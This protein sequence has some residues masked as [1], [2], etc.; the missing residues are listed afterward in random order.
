M[1]ITLTGPNAHNGMFHVHQT[2]CRDL[3]RA[4]YNRMRGEHGERYEEEHAS[5]EEVVLSVY[6]NGILDHDAGET[7]ADYVGEFKF[8]PCTEGLPDTVKGPAGDTHD[9]TSDADIETLQQFTVT[10][11]VTVYG[12]LAPTAESALALVDAAFDDGLLDQVSFDC[13]AHASA[14]AVLL[15][16]GS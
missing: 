2:G 5:V 8:F 15:K 6:D 10:M 1:N 3:S 9:E 7:W 16:D 14:S 11:T 12:V 13:W 4:P